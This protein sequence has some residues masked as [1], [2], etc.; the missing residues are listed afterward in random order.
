MTFCTISY[1][2]RGVNK[3][4][5]TGIEMSKEPRPRGRPRTYDSG[6]AL[7]RATDVFWAGGYAGSSLDELG[8]AMAM[9][10]PSLYLA[11]GDKEALYLRTLERY[12]AESL[13]ALQAAL[14]PGESLRTGL[15]TV[16]ARSIASYLEGHSGPRGCLLI[17]TAA[18]EA[19]GN[20]RVREV[21]RASLESFE[22]AFED[23]F[24]TAQE[25]GEVGSDADVGGLARIASATLHSLA[26][27][28]RAGEVREALEAVA[29]ATV[30][31]ICG[32][33]GAATG[34]G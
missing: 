18:T 32:P 17:G 6:T 15:Q 29:K 33:E 28:A 23:R 3:Y 16:Y 14:D 10:R 20:P 4:V 27:R 11:F 21:L 24:R 19:V 13:I 34:S 1:I 5:R 7:A 9:S 25:R 30:D 12:Q 31:V 22:K 2:K 8:S 26:V